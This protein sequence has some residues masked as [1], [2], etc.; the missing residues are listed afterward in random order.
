MYFTSEL[1]SEMLESLSNQMV[2]SFM[3]ILKEI[4]V[5]FM[6][7][8][9]NVFH[10]AQNEG[11]SLYFSNEFAEIRD[12]Y[13]KE[14]SDKLASLF[15]V[16]GEKPSE[17]R[18]SVPT[19]T[20][21]DYTRQALHNLPLDI[22]PNCKLF[23]LDRTVDMISPLMHEFTYLAMIQD[24]LCDH[25]EED[26]FKYSCTTF[27]GNTVERFYI[28]DEE[29]HVLSRLRH[30][31]ISDGIEWLASNIKQFVKNEQEYKS[32]DINSSLEVKDMKE[33]IYHFSKHQEL[34][35]KYSIHLDFVQMMSDIFKSR[36][37]E[38]IA[39]VQQNIAT[40][41]DTSGKPFKTS[42]EIQNMSMMFKDTSISKMD[43]LRT[44]LIMSTSKKF[45][46]SQIHDLMKLRPDFG[47]DDFRAVCNMFKMTSKVN[48]RHL[49]FD[50]L[51]K[52]NRK[53]QLSDVGF[54]LSRWSP[55]MKTLIGQFCAN[56]LSESDYPKI[57]ISNRH[58]ANETHNS[59]DGTLNSIIS[60]SSSNVMNRI[61]VFVVGGITFS[62]MRVVHELMQSNP[63]IEIILGSTH[64][65]HPREFI[66]DMSFLNNNDI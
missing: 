50:G 27:E 61:I 66:E 26:K 34:K 47:E 24:L 29:D 55:V 38:Q 28:L 8:E 33:M 19:F 25:I 22:N 65:I 60:K 53:K 32:D 56:N 62:E 5:E 59:D 14:L 41:V 1:T 46:Q 2:V 54:E 57:Q 23:I 20:V 31:H 37:L 63:R 36:K 44:I 4:N 39:G 21:A 7:Y 43:L 3:R 58:S 15:A 18:Y 52:K 11:F 17:I 12:P 40:G 64:I 48:I 42:R 49:Q 51:S 10:L 9:P 45:N 13:Q 6:V 16:I 35:S 30:K